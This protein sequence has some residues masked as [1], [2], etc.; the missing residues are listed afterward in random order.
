MAWVG[1]LVLAMPSYTQH[2]HTTTTCQ[3]NPRSPTRQHDD[4]GRLWTEATAA[5]GLRRLE[6]TEPALRQDLEAALAEG[7][8]D[9]ALELVLGLRAQG[10][11]PSVAAVD[12][13]LRLLLQQGQADRAYLLCRREGIP[14]HPGSYRT[15]L[16]AL[17]SSSGNDSG[18]GDPS[19]AAVTA[20]SSSSAP[21]KRLTQA[22]TLLEE[23]RTW[24]AG[25]TAPGPGHY[26]AVLGGC[27]EAGDWREALRLRREMEDVGLMRIGK[28]KGGK[29]QEYEDD[30]VE[31]RARGLVLRALARDG[32]GA[33]ALR[34]LEE[35]VGNSDSGAF[36]L[37][38]AA[39]VEGTALRDGALDGA[40][41]L[42]GE[43]IKSSSSP[44]ALDA[45]V[46]LALLGACKRLGLWEEALALLQPEVPSGPAPLLTPGHAALALGACG[47][48][49]PPQPGAALAL[50]K[51]MVGG[52]GGGGCLG[53]QPDAVAYLELLEAC[54]RGGRGGE[55]VALLL[56][57]PP[58]PSS[59]SPPPAPTAAAAG[60][61]SD[62]TLPPP[63]DADL[64]AY[65][66]AMRASLRA[67]DHMAVLRLWAALRARGVPPAR[68][69]RNYLLR[70]G[71]NSGRWKEALAAL[72][73]EAAGAAGAAGGVQGVGEEE[74][75][76]GMLL[77][78]EAEDAGLAN[79][80]DNGGGGGGVFWRLQAEPALLREVF[81]VGVTA[82]EREGNWGGLL[83]VLQDMGRA[84]APPPPPRA[85]SGD[86]GA[87][88]DVIGVVGER[89]RSADG[90]RPPPS[91]V[92]AVD[93]RLARTCNRAVTSAV[94]ERRWE[95]VGG[96]RYESV[97]WLVVVLPLFGFSSPVTHTHAHIHTYTHNTH[98]PSPSTPP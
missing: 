73:E 35:E 45:A 95:Q 18:S 37:G 64:R 3:P 8:A 43:V 15:V 66:G 71:L 1:R 89:P 97:V 69:T 93:P 53:V 80:N 55:A 92:I 22:L 76:G 26:L 6:T 30:D 19:T 85:P 68:A 50:F 31:A 10:L 74:G 21:S 60:N 61:E 57:A 39:V 59:L 11:Y 7:K 54:G 82:H 25:G 14:V 29:E 16:E 67:K 58:P 38:L 90:E 87:A 36:A 2:T 70:A 83:M 17:C 96:G 88:D 47:A 9:A 32:Q 24:A 44:A 51:D 13:L 62:D 5:Q 52:G 63:Y 65:H 86:E 48:A 46:R 23:M 20:A 33:K 84:L 49:T 75:E 78:S 98:R 79:D 77:S 40:R 27:A 81:L 56:K 42:A 28:G 94:R 34:L 91:A 4:T 41:Q 72:E 12:R